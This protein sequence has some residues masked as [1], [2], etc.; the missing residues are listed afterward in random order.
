MVSANQLV[1]DGDGEDHLW[2]ILGWCADHG[3]KRGRL[4]RGPQTW[5]MFIW[6]FLDK[7]TMIHPKPLDFMFERL[8]LYLAVSWSLRI[9][10]LVIPL[11]RT[12]KSPLKSPL[13]HHETHHQ[14]TIKWPWT[15]PLTI[16]SPLRSPLRSPLKSHHSITMKFSWN[17]TIKI[18]IKS[19]LD[20]Q[21]HHQITI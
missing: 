11:N 18:T 6:F 9:I 5:A 14:I 7:V 21:K 16:K 4:G 1:T 13:N 20:Q 10:P 2:I 17:H 15:T 12:I 19:L 3:L 8:K